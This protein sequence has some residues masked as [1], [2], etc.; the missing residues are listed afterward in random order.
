MTKVK[1]SSGF[2]YEIDE[3]N[4]NDMRLLDIIAEISNGDTTKL[5]LMISMIIGDQK[6]KLYKNLEDEKGRVP[7][8]KA[9]DEITEI[10]QKI[11]TG[12]NS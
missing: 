7:V 12:K 5:P 2:E 11:N 4:L 6:E 10:F 3:E 1:T 8:Q 9:S